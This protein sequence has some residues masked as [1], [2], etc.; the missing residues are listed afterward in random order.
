VSP[1]FQ[2]LAARATRTVGTPLPGGRFQP[3]GG[4]VAHQQASKAATAHGKSSQ[5]ELPEPTGTDTCGTKPVVE[6]IRTGERIT[7][8]EVRCG[9]G[10]V[11]TI[12][13]AYG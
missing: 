3:L 4:G 13:C 1:A 5:A 10:K 6:A 11:I 7:H 12:E 2:P 9:C 8:L